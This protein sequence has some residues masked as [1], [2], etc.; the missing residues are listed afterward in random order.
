MIL[1]QRLGLPDLDPQI[2]ARINE[3]EKIRMD[4]IRS[5]RQIQYQKAERDRRYEE[6]QSNNRLDTSGYTGRPKY[7]F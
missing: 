7:V 4:F 1:R 3:F 6:R 2:I 5:R